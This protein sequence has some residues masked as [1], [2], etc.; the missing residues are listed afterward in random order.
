MQSSRLLS[1]MLR[2][3]TQGRVTAAALAA[4]LEVS[5]RTI[6][7]D[8]DALSAAGVPV[9]AEKGRQG[10]FALRDGY[11]TRLTGLDRPEAE[12]L[13]FAGVPFAA[14]QLGLGPALDSTRLK[15]LAA[16]PEA[17]Q[18]DAQRVASRFHLD[19]VGWFQ[20]PDEQRLLPQLA[21]AVWA[22]RT[23]FIRYESWKAVV[24]RR[25]SP[26]GLVLKAGLWY[27]VAAVDA[28]VRTY[29]VG[30]IQALVVEDT[31]GERPAQFDLAEHWRRFTTDYEAR[32]QAGRAR[33]RARPAGLKA[34]ARMSHAMAQ[35]VAAAGP[36]NR[37]GWHVLD[38][39]IESVDG[40]VGEL[41]RLGPDVQA[42]AP[43]EL[44]AALRG[45]VQ[46]LH[47]VYARPIES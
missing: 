40:A 28:Q 12:S 32:M 39:P 13:F 23:V 19:P 30:G 14:E 37:A 42:L 35:A 9:Y 38:I 45:A 36:R 47:V 26:L 11:R 44:R 33:V 31:A 4:A 8:I 46:A 20:G 21:A 25:V 41:L 1:I 22:G 29:R 17:A 34:L 24:D 15:L 43:P 5:V 27:L 18:A 16:L 6:Y 3:Q 2:L 10:G 7:R